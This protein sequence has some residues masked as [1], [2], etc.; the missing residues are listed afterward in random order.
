M[1]YEDS[2]KRIRLQY[3]SSDKATLAMASRLFESVLNMGKLKAAATG[4][5]SSS[6]TVYPLV[7]IKRN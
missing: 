7:T 3:Q 2:Q 6:F 4:L 1:T 5:E